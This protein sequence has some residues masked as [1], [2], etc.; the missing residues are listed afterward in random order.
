MALTSQNTFKPA[1]VAADLDDSA[2]DVASDDGGSS[3]VM[4]FEDFED[5]D[6]SGGENQDDEGADSQLEQEE[7]TAGPSRSAST[8]KHLY[9]PP[10]VS[11]IDLL[12]SSTSN[13]TF[14]LQVDALVT[15]TLLAKTADSGLSPLLAS[16]HSH[17][18]GLPHLPS[19]SPSKAAKRLKGFKIPFVGPQEYNPIRGDMNELEM[20]NWVLGWDKPE[21][22]FIGGSWGVV[23]GYK[24]AKGEAGGVDLLIVMPEV[25]STSRL[26]RRT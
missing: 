8:S 5:E 23:G 1:P 13:S 24:K 6:E 20:P 11:D 10:T 7:P 25:R 9:K 22:I 26:R 18:L 4:E 21:E 15:S 19:L 16:L 3:D 17:I 14:D 12:A 2:S